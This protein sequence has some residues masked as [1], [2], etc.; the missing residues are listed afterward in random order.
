MLTNISPSTKAAGFWSAVIATL[1]AIA[2]DVGQIAEWLGLLGSGGGAHNLSTPLGIVVL[3]TPS[4]ILGSSFLIL[5]VSVHQAAPPERKVWS[6]VAVVF[7]TIYAAL[8]S[9]NYYVQL[10]WVGPRLARGKIEGM[11]AFLFT[12]F[13]SFLYAVDILGYSF[14][15]LATFFVAKALTGDGLERIARFFLVANGLLIPFIA[16]QMYVHWFIWLAAPW[17]ITFP[18]ATWTLALLF[19]SAGTQRV[20]ARPNW[21]EVTAPMPKAAQ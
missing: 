15:S 5:M 19:R 8:I 7:A 9:I 12:P 13:D 3:L 10:T 14:M 16:L 2:Y 4:L 20:A 11:E 21:S 1:C 17:S 6:H 18:G